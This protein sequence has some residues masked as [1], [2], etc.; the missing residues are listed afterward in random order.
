MFKRVFEKSSPSGESERMSGEQGQDNTPQWED[1][2]EKMPRE[3]IGER[4]SCKL[5]ES[6]ESLREVLRGLAPDEEGNQVD[7]YTVFQNFNANEQEKNQETLGWRELTTNFLKTH[8]D[9]TTNWMK[10]HMRELPQ[11]GAGLT[12]PAA[13]MFIDKVNYLESQDVWRLGTA[14]D[15]LQNE[16]YQNNIALSYAPVLDMIQNNDF[17]HLVNCVNSEGLMKH[18]KVEAR[19]YLSPTVENIVPLVQEIIQKHEAEDMRYYL[20]FAKKGDVKGRIVLYTNYKNIEK[21]LELLH[22]I[23]GEHPEL[24][25]EMGKNPLWGTIDG[26]PEGVYFG[27]QPT[28]QQSY[29]RVRSQVFDRAYAKWK[30]D[31]GLGE[32]DKAQ[33]HQVV[34][35]GNLSLEAIKYFRN[36][37]EREAYEAGIGWTKDEFCFN[38]A[39]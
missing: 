17:V 39:A 34:V 7:A 22:N 35:E 11:M 37:V 9:K 15:I 29:D 12:R 3:N 23:Q 30:E 27:E 24:F 10:S 31:C 20:K 32:I 8:L 36:V 2:I 4:V 28:G 25:T 14:E 38:R 6:D 33:E 1:H 18:D 26:A 19:L 13:E 21:N 16:T 5:L